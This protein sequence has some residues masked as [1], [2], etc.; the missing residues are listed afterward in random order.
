MERDKFISM[1]TL[2]TQ[3]IQNSSNFATIKNVDYLGT[4]KSQL[5]DNSLETT[6]SSKSKIS[7][8]C[9]SNDSLDLESQSDIQNNE[10]PNAEWINCTIL[11]NSKDSHIKTTT[12]Y[13]SVSSENEDVCNEQKAKNNTKLSNI[14]NMRSSSIKRKKN[15]WLPHE[16]DEVIRLINLYGQSWS[17][18]SGIIK[19]R[20]G[21]QVRDRYLNYLRPDLKDEN[22]SEEED[23][24]LVSLYLKFGNRWS[25]IA[26]GI[27]GRSECQVKNRFHAFTKKNLISTEIS[28]ENIHMPKNSYIPRENFSNKIKCETEGI[29]YVKEESSTKDVNIKKEEGHTEAMQTR[30]LGF[31]N[32]ESRFSASFQNSIFLNLHD[33]SKESI[34]RSLTSTLD[35]GKDS[36]R[37]NELFSR[38]DM[39]YNHGLFAS[40]QDCPTDL[41]SL[42]SYN[43][44]AQ[45]AGYRQKDEKEKHE[46]VLENMKHEFSNK[47][48]KQKYQELVRRKH[49]L[50]FFYRK[51]LEEM[52]QL[53][54]IESFSSNLV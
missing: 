6:N 38:E 24:L 17:K 31:I 26:N 39:R 48:I 46:L 54:K 15:P 18:I 21:K 53:E 52:T 37:L 10:I 42:K 5:L 34:L 40:I 36:R 16:D 49:A 22:F 23:Q 44:S 12:E 19:N 32:Q 51:T 4:I 11:I 47:E 35:E 3:T 25:K 45:T 29:L 14:I 7:E 20:T 41:N 33:A 50:E 1:Q 8:F 9:A 27:P 43:K 28:S 13:P 30:F 2:N